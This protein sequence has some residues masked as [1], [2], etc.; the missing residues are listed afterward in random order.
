MMLNRIIFDLKHLISS[1]YRKALYFNPI[2][3]RNLGAIV[4]SNCRFYSINFSTEPY[5]IKI[6]N[7]VTITQ[8]VNFSTQDGAVRVFRNLIPDIELFGQIRI[9]MNS[10]ILFNTE[11]GDNCVIAAGS[12]VKGKFHNNSIIAGVHAKCIGS[13][14]D[15]FKKNEICFTYFRNL[16][17]EAKVSE[18]KSRFKINNL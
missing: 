6:G 13:I 11:I 4:G 14:D 8:N 10:T 2:I 15:Y 12:V 3:A 7:H 18:V 1:Y 17:H 9:G 16:S 5:L